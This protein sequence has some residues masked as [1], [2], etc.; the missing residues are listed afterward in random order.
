MLKWHI[1]AQE[2]YTV[3]EVSNHFW[4]PKPLKYSL[5]WFTIGSFMAIVNIHKVI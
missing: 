1:V 5:I 4:I 3:V 2:T